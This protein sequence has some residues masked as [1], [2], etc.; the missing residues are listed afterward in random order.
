MFR[1]SFISLL[2]HLFPLLHYQNTNS[3]ASFLALLPAIVPLHAGQK[4]K[5]KQAHVEEEHKVRDGGRYQAHC[6]Y[7]NPLS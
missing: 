5:G 1:L 4:A 7:N 3:F 2:F 6:I